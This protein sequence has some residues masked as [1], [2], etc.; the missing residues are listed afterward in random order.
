MAPKCCF[1]ILIGLPG[2][3]KTSLAKRLC[4]HLETADP[5]TSVVHISY[6]DLIPLDLQA[7]MSRD[8]SSGEW[9]EA[10]KSV[11]GAVDAWLSARD[12]LDPEVAK[13][14][15]QIFASAKSEMKDRVTLVIDDNNYYSS[16][17]Y[18]FCQLA[19]KHEAGFCQISVK[20]KTSTAVARNAA[21]AAEN[22]V[23]AETIE[24]M[25]AKL[26]EPAPMKNAWES[27]S[28]SVD[29]ERADFA[30]DR[31]VL[32]TVK[33]VVD[34]AYGNPAKTRPDNVAERDHS[35]KVCSASVIHQA[36]KIL[37][38]KI[39]EKMKALKEEGAEK[40]VMTSKVATF[41]EA[42]SELLEDFRTGFTKLPREIVEAWTSSSVKAM[43][44]Y[45]E[46]ASTRDEPEE[47]GFEPI[48]VPESSKPE[49]SGSDEG[50]KP[51]LER[52]EQVLS[53]LFELKLGKGPSHQ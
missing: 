13:V 4:R 8:E 35:R 18:E 24:K 46:S 2:S 37:R 25:A 6:D 52:L 42:R 14:R 29:G 10:R 33:S 30:E 17:R 9:K 32:D 45:A 39:G 5:D 44:K 1:L 3:G 12:D 49:Q 51:D 21:R 16:M 28:F 36:D 31:Q 22:R 11:H 20:V 34:L 43:S 40:E 27:F 47:T 7:E 53:D 41:N 15:E 50:R 23:P 26:D 38:K 48:N 19:R